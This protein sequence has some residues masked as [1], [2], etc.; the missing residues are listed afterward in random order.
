M[1]NLFG[2]FKLSFFF[3][4][5]YTSVYAGSFSEF[6][7]SQADA[8]TEFTNKEDKLF[9]SYL[10]SN[11]EAYLGEMTPPLYQQVKPVT[12][13]KKRPTQIKKAGPI[14]NLVKQLETNQTKEIL[15]VDKK[16]FIKKDISF[17]F[18]GTQLSYTIPS[19]MKKA[20][21]YPQTQK[22][23]EN[24]YNIII[25]SEYEL[26]LKSIN[27]TLKIM[28]LN[29]W[30]KYL[31]IKKI[32][33]AMFENQDN[34]RLLRWFIFNKLGYSV[35]VGLS[36]K[37]ILVMYKS[38]SS[39]YNAP[40]YTIGGKKF[41]LISNYAKGI[42]NKVYTYTQ[43]YPEAIKSLDL[44]M[45]SLPKLEKHFLMKN[46]SFKDNGKIYNIKYTYNKN[47]LDFMATYPQ[48]DYKI[49]F[50]TPLS[51]E[52]YKDIANALRKYINGKTTTV[53]L[54]FVLRFVQKAFKYEVDAQQFGKEKVMFGEETLYYDKS[55]CEDR[56]ILYA[57][58]VK[59][60]FSIAVV[61]VQYKDHMATAIYVP[62]KGDSVR[63]NSRRFLIADPTYINAS[64]GQS[65]NKYKTKKPIQ[66]VYLN[67][68]D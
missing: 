40:I 6:K 31:L 54:N 17:D 64:I 3:L 42:N 44:S 61:G 12:L 67:K 28:N 26:L 2:H 43:D 60:L 22:G 35:R 65:M 66:F 46:L 1:Y 53:G 8:F 16:N 47:L 15:R 55:D 49:F 52:T 48:V 39:I 34:A 21:F 41:Y 51:D 36:Q 56:A 4:L 50:N 14:I 5:F 13:P 30:G 10:K 27:K 57:Y 33:D 24:Y 9:N 38:D 32:S 45:T 68:K 18:F 37:H 29:D 11:W 63:V 62:I 19:G 20:K 23:I 58:L 25:S 59:K 7:K